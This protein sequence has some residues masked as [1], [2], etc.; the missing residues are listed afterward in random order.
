MEAASRNLDKPEGAPGMTAVVGLDIDEIRRII[1]DIDDVYVAN[2]NSPIQTVLSGSHSGLVR[3]EAAMDEA[4]AMQVVRLKVSGPF[5]SPLMEDARAAFAEGIDSV[6]FNDPKIPVISNVTGKE[7]RD[8]NEARNG[9]L[10]QIVSM[11]RWVDVESTVLSY[12]PELI[13]ETGPGTVLRGLWKSF[14]KKIKCQSA[15][16]AETIGKLTS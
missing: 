16:S 5:H 13:L 15:G 3:A 2:H 9:C 4:E 10:E 14:N 7:L 1:A 11:V 8:A 6:Q 12:N